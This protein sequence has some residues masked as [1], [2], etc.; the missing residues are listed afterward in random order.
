MTRPGSGDDGT[1]TCEHPTGAFTVALDIGVD[2]ET[3]ALDVR[4]AGIIRTAR[5][6]MDGIVFPAEY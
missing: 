6:L 2:A 4:R 5:K 1:L 3:G